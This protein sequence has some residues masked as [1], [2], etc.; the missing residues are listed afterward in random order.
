MH[1]VC[2]A[3]IL[4]VL[5]AAASQP[6]AAAQQSA[7]NLPGLEA[8]WDIAAVLQEIGKHAD[9]LL[10]ALER[11]DA[12]AWVDQGASETYT[13]QLQLC[14]D[15]TKTVG[16]AARELA[17]NPEQLGS[18]IDLFIR[19]QILEVML[20]SIEE[21][22]RK[23]QTPADAQ[24]LAALEAQDSANRGRFQRYIVNLASTREQEL[25]VMDKEAQRCR[26]LVTAPPATASKS[27]KKK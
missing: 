27:V 21:G 8:D 22:I 9:R 11:I 24:S 12:R 25:K 5:V 16:D 15:Q 4:T 14:K 19:M 20:L 1:R 10:P 17:R 7:S 18:S 3:A 23:Y 2:A 26:G 6:Q 13:E